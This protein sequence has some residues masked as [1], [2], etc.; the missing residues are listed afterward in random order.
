[1]IQAKYGIIR[2]NASLNERHRYSIN[3]IDCDLQLY[4]HSYDKSTLRYDSYEIIYIERTSRYSC[5]INIVNMNKLKS[6]LT[7]NSEIEII[8]KITNRKGI[9]KIINN[10]L[11]FYIKYLRGDDIFD[12][13]KF[14]ND[15]KIYIEECLQKY[16]QLDFKKHTL[17]KASYD[18]ADRAYVLSKSDSYKNL[19]YDD[20]NNDFIDFKEHYYT[21]TNYFNYIIENFCGK[22]FMLIREYKG[23]GRYHIYTEC[24]IEAYIQ[25][26]NI[27]VFKIL[28]TSTEIRVHN[29]MNVNPLKDYNKT[30]RLQKIEK[31]I[32]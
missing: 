6:Y 8:E 5:D 12:Y 9:Y 32:N 18:V 4:N 1:M 15:H 20:K 11:T 31:I 2:A 13:K 28:K 27:I 7:S 24:E 21:D 22:N 16:K 3:N 14:L 10:N 19:I 17:I 25:E 30:K 29:D 26:D 23:E